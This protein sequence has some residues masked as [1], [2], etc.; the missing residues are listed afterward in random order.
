V[1]YEPGTLRA[2][3]RRDGQIVAQEE[4]RTAGVP[5]AIALKCDKA[6]LSSGARGVAQIEVTILDA[7]AN[8]VPTADNAVTFDVQ[9][10]ARIIGVDNGDPSSHESYQGNA[11][12]AFNGRALAIVQAGKTP[13]HVTVTAKAEGLRDASVEFDVQAGSSVPALP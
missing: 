10:P 8:L 9:G 1:P 7:E 12:L 6:A 11:R 2:F 13:G 3:G 5:A 4:I